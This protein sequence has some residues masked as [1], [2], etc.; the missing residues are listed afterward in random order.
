MATGTEAIKI[1][2]GALALGF[3]LS[4][5]L[6]RALGISSWASLASEKPYSPQSVSM[7]L[8]AYEGRVYPEIRND[9]CSALEISRE[10][11]DALIARQSTDEAKEGVA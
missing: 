10:Y 7:C 1:I 4:E 6:Q 11:L 2:E 5:A 3:S 8:N 9:I